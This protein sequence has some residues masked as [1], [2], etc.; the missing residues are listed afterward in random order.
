MSPSPEPGALFWGWWHSLSAPVLV[1]QMVECRLENQRRTGI[2]IKNVSTVFQ[3]GFVFAGRPLFE[4]F[5]ERFAPGERH[6]FCPAD[7]SRIVESHK[8]RP[9]V[10]S[11]VID[12]KS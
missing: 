10:T 12:R 11:F 8:K 7:F 9:P 3:T 2:R 4:L 6:K 5:I 1:L